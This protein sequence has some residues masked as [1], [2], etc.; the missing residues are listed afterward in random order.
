MGRDTMDRTGMV[1]MERGKMSEAF[2]SLELAQALKTIG[3]PQDQ[4]PQMVY[5][6]WK[7]WRGTFVQY[8][9]AHRH[10]MPG[11]QHDWYAAPTPLQTLEWMER[12]KGSWWERYVYANTD[13]ATVDWS[14]C[15]RNHGRVETVEGTDPN[16]LILA[17]LKHLQEAQ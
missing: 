16:D 2:V 7:V 3:Y 10:T 6:R 4:W 11:D 13:P 14:I 17:I 9:L 12:E 5:W 1:G 15:W 8:T